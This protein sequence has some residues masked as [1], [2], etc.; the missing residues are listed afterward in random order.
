MSSFGKKRSASMVEDSDDSGAEVSPKVSKKS[1]KGDAGS[2][3]GEDDEGNPFWEVSCI[4]I[5]QCWSSNANLCA[6]VQ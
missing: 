3:D 6:A 1:K 5:R 2:P 4:H